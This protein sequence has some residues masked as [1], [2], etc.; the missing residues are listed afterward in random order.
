M[1]Q[2][3]VNILTAAENLFLEDG[4]SRTNMTQVARAAGV[5]RQSV[6]AHFENK[7]ALIAAVAQQAMKRIVET[8]NQRWRE[9]RTLAEKLE[10]FFQVA[11]LEPFRIFQTHPELKLLLQGGSERTVSVVRCADQDIAEALARQLEPYE[12]AFKSAQ[13]S[14]EE[15]ADYT[16]K[17]SKALK[18]SATSQGEL[19]R[20]LDLLARSMLAMVGETS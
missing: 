4:P 10:V 9:C 3:Q 15:V 18:Y 13:T 12:P 16:T 17:A 5:S 11:V 7:D 19:E 1:D 14:P 2:T 8:L 6:Y 20:H